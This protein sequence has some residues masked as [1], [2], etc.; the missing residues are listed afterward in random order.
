[1]QCFSPAQC[2]GYVAFVL[3]VAAFL[4]KDD[5]RL[6]LLIASESLAYTVHFWM[7]GNLPASLGAFTSSARSYL[8]TRTRSRVLAVLIIGINVALGLAFAKSCAA[9]F[10]ILASCL[11]TIAV[12]LL[13]GVAMRLVMLVCTFLWLANNI[14]SGSIGGTL[15]EMVIGIVNISTIIRLFLAPGNGAGSGAVRKSSLLTS[16][17]G[18][19][20][21]FR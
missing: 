19:R 16:F 18:L 14:L 8:A 21:L 3:G 4:Q 2:V 20:I 12:F 17:R 1:M 5:R 6:K 10:P 15:L 9:W 7:L 13:Q 11:G